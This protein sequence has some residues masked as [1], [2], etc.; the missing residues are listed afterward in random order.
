[1]Q[2]AGSS[3][4]PAGINATTT[5]TTTRHLPFYETLNDIDEAAREIDDQ[6]VLGWSSKDAL[7]RVKLALQTGRQREESGDIPRALFWYLRAIAFVF[8]SLF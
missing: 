6:I 4:Q 2:P 8:F 3:R 5:I 1:M 7:R